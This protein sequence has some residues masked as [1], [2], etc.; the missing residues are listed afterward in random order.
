MNAVD[1]I[2]EALKAGAAGVNAAV[3]TIGV[4]VTVR[5]VSV[6]L[7][8]AFTSSGEPRLLKEAWDAACEAANRESPIR[9]GRY[10]FAD[11][12]SILQW[13]TRYKTDET[14]AYLSAP[15]VQQTGSLTVIVD[16]LPSGSAGTTRSVRASLAI[17]LHERLK[18]WIACAGSWHAAEAFCSFVDMAGDELVSSDLITMTQNLE[19]RGASTWKRTVDEKGAVRVQTEDQSGPAT[20]IPRDFRF[21]VP[22]FETDE[23]SMVFAAKLFSKVEKGQPLFQFS[24]SDLK[25]TIAGAM[26]SIAV[27][28]AEVVNASQVYAGTAP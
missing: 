21:A 7:P 20:R 1:N 22:A 17:S 26:T 27:Q 14:S 19:V 9:A 4:S 23:A 5:G 16:D 18:A 8:Y 3:R 11:I 2:A 12:A 6:E 10:A 28:V 15:T 24:I 25:K 13:A